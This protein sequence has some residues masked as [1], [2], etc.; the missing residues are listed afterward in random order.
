MK[1][2]SF[3]KKEANWIK[4]KGEDS[5]IIVSSRIR[6]AR[7][8]KNY[9]FPARSKKELQKKIR[10][11]IISKIKKISYLKNSE[12]FLIEELTPTDKR[13]LV[14]RHLI[15]YDL[16]KSKNIG[17]I[18]IGDN[19]ILSIMVNEED[20][21][22]IQ[23]LNPGLNLFDTYNIVSVVDDELSKLL[24]Y[25]YSE[26]F[27]YLTSC[28][29]NVGTGM[30]ASV[31]L[32]LPAIVKTNQINMLLESLTRLGM[33]ARGFYGEGTKS[34][35][36]FF[37]VSNQITLGLS[38]REIVDKLERVVK[39]IIK[40]EKEVRESYYKREKFEIE[41]RVLRSYGVLKYAVKLSY[42]ELMERI[43]YLRMGIGL[44]IKLPVTI[45]LINKIML[46][47][48]P[49]HLEERLGKSLNFNEQ[50]IE[51]AKLVKSFL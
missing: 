4:E 16:A 43:S 11:E 33:V 29:T 44:G 22:R 25:A 10:D 15:S 1:L 9:P 30:R 6:L 48:Q 24:S 5:D 7:N 27:G 18:V 17:A 31:L 32:H 2:T 51:R 8:L 50:E 38:E 13:F 34:L 46:L 45:E 41:D 23:G 12:I 35:G 39:E 49:A 47:S 28:P 14:E 21:L 20:H 42:Q 40:K 37:Q 19:E 36:D 26:E 3:L